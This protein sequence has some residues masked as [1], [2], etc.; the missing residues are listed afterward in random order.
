MRHVTT[1][2]PPLMPIFRSEVQARILAWLLLDPSREQPIASLAPVAGTVQST[3]LREVNQLLRGGLLAERRVGN[4]RLVRADVDSPYYR[5]L[6]E[7]LARSYGPLTAVPDELGSVPGIEEVWIVGSWAERFS[8]EPGPPPRDV[9]VVVVGEPLGRAL[10]RATS[11]LEER[12]G[13]A[14][15]VTSIDRHEWDERST[16][17]VATVRAGH[18]VQVLPEVTG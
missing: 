17:F 7:I 12:L 3:V 11:K 15:Q 6:T 14:V 5:P 4:A 9:D 16:P 1:S 18:P 13:L 8:G 2:A 10:R